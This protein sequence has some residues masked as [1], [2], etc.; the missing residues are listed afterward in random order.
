MDELTIVIGSVV[1]LNELL[2]VLV[3]CFSVL[4]NALES[5][6]ELQSDLV[7]VRHQTPVIV[8]HG[9]DIVEPFSWICGDACLER[10]ILVSC[11]DGS[12][13]KV[14]PTVGASRNIQSLRSLV[15][16]HDDGYTLLKKIWI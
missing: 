14:F 3:N 1:L 7:H 13:T 16:G 6:G 11:P 9:L 4:L 8:L 2:F 15:I 10:S 12:S 5:F